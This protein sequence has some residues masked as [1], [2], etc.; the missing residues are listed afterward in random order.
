MII[1]YIK[2]N[3]LVWFTNNGVWWIPSNFDYTVEDLTS[4]DITNLKNWYSYIDGMVVMEWDWTWWFWISEVVQLTTEEL[5]QQSYSIQ[6]Q[7]NTLMFWTEQEITDMK[8]AIQSII[9]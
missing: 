8:T 2:W 4:G 3:K 7:L 5:I 9:W 1:A 6:E